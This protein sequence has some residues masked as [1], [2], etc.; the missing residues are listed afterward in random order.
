MTETLHIKNLTKDFGSL[1]A[2]NNISFTARQGEIIALLGPNGAGKSTLMN[3]ITGYLAPT[4]G[5]ISVLG[6]KIT[7]NCLFAK[8]NI[9]FLPEGSPLYI[10]EL[11][12]LAGSKKD[13][14]LARVCRLSQIDSV[15]NQ[16]IETLSKGY[17]RRVGFA[18][19][20]L[21]N[22]PILLLDEPTDGLDPNQK[23]HIRRQI[24]ELGRHKTILISTH[25]LDEAETVCNRIILIDRGAVK[26]DGTLEDILLQTKTSGLEEAFKKLTAGGKKHA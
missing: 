15:W 8:Q 14:R 2:V 3:M 24:G 20:I 5:E 4:S 21:S 18:Q 7:D 23:E 16:K 19:S 1:R 26:A 13:E 25:L 11:R 22:P 17:R 6:C 9:G 10:A 12:G